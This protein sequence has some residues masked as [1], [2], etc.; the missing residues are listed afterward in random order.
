MMENGSAWIDNSDGDFLQYSFSPP[1][2]WTSERVAA[3]QAATIEAIEGTGVDADAAA[4]G[5]LRLARRLP[6]GLRAALVVELRV[7]NRLSGI[8]SSGWPHDG[9]VVVNLCE[10]FSASRRALP[11]GVVWRELNDPH[12]AREELSAQAGSVASLII[13]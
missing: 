5:W 13:T 9:S 11:A 8:G 10:R 6:D 4:P 3:E 2:H 12:Y 1:A 7:G